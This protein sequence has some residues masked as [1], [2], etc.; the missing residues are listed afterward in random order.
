MNL[1][2][3]SHTNSSTL[4]QSIFSRFVAPVSLATSDDD[5]TDKMVLI[6]RIRTLKK[7]GVKF[8]STLPIPKHLSCTFAPV[9]DPTLLPFLC[10]LTSSRLPLSTV[11]APRRKNLYDSSS[12][13]PKPP[14]PHSTP[15][16]PKPPN[17]A[18]LLHLPF[19]LP[20]HSS[21]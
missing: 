17:P 21:T 2:S 15:V 1:L 7:A 4:C 14:P 10:L 11:S 5:R 16:C 9:S 20:P 12:H 6:L 8:S 3:P 19:T 13:L 18:S